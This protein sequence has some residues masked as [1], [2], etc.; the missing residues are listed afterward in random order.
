MLQLSRD[1]A[2]YYV[3]CVGLALTAGTEEI[4]PWTRHDT[5]DGCA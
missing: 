5:L 3:L 1:S 4:G 2:I